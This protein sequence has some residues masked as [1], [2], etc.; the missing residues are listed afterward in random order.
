MVATEF[1]G[2]W[3]KM[4]EGNFSYVNAE[5]IGLFRK[6]MCKKTYLS[7]SERSVR[8][9]KS[10]KD[11]IL[12]LCYKAPDD[13]ILKQLLIKKDVEKLYHIKLCCC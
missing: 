7:K 8:G 12:F 4:I 10:A 13:R 1:H 11:K 2:Q 6:K 9:I 3:A 5:K